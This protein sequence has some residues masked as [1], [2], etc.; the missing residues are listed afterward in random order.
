MVRRRRTGMILFIALVV[1][2][3]MMLWAIA[4]TARA[5]FQSG[6]VK[7]S[8]RKS[9]CHYLVKTAINRSLALVNANPA[10]LAAHRGRSN[11]DTTTTPGAECWAE[12]TNGQTMLRGEARI[13][14]QSAHLD[15]PLLELDD[16]DTQVL[17]ITPS[18]SGGP[19]LIAWTSKTTIGWHPLPP[20]PGQTKI[21]ATAGAPNLDVFA[22]TQGPTNNILWRYRTGQGWRQMPDTP[23]GVSLTSLSVGGDIRLIGRGSDNSL[24]V[25]PLGTSLNWT[26]VPAP[27]GTTLT[28][29]TA[30]P[31]GED[32]AYVTAFDGTSEG[33]RICDLNTRLWSTL[34]APVAEHY[35]PVTGASTGSGG[36][37]TSFT[38]GLA[39]DNAGD[40]FVAAN[41]PGEA[42]V[43]YKFDA[44]SSGSTT[45]SW[46]AL[47]PVP[48]LTF[49]NQNPQN[50][51]TDLRNLTA[52]D[53]GYLWVQRNDPSSSS[54]SIIGVQP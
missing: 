21:L 46:S 30:H 7:F 45:G 24:M 5:N 9:E 28:N 38:G 15:V 31:T 34:P 51:C 41:Q 17:S 16:S 40:V 18:L 25:L 49:Q 23:A 26:Q 14:A 43:I 37:L 20:I 36:P 3:I 8:Y 2:M 52:D 4:A 32:R 53:D 19:D 11:A 6:A 50:Y 48:A 27:A 42:S 54:F 12:V 44:V 33:V 29:V 39:V 1:A 10:W 22:L 13:G 47:P 35:D